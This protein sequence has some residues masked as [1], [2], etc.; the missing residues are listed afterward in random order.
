[1]DTNLVVLGDGGFS[2]EKDNTILDDYI[3]SLSKHQMPRICFL[4]TASGDSIDYLK[5]FYYCFQPQRARPYHLAV[6]MPNRAKDIRAFLLSMDIIYVGGGNTLN[7]ITLLRLHNLV[8]P[9][10]EA[11]TAGV[12]LAGISA[13]MVCWYEEFL[14]DS[15]LG[16]GLRPYKEGLGFLTGSACAH[17][18]EPMHE[19]L[20]KKL[21]R[22]GDLKEG[23]GLDGNAGI[24]YVNGKVHRVISS[25]AGKTAHFI[26]KKI[27]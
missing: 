9:L 22:S 12:V 5:K 14:T 21:V 25:V 20:Y 11:Y 24:H 16:G 26:K 18:D 7:L 17:F 8:G 15:Y 13:G 3:L 19:I 1:M 4:A 23:V 27:A 10:A 2:N 6:F